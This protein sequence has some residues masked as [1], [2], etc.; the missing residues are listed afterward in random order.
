MP[1]FLAICTIPGLDEAKLR[2]VFPGTRTS[3]WRP[4]ARTTILKVLASSQAGKVLA[5]CDAVEQ[6]HF[7]AWLQKVGWTPDAVY[8]VDYVKQGPNFWKV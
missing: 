4:D 8:R 5:E 7:E 3:E 2:Q 1:R 6:A